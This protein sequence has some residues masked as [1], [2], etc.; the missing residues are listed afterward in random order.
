MES[1][2]IAEIIDP[3]TDK[4]VQ[5]GQTGELV[6][7]NLGRVCTPGIRFR[8]RDI[9]KSSSRQCGCGR[10]FRM[11]EG[12]V[13][14]RQDQ[15]VKIRGTNIFPSS[16]GLIVEKYV[17]PGYEYRIIAFRENDRDNIKIL[18]EKDGSEDSLKVFAHELG[19]ELK[20]DF[21]LNFKVEVLEKG[22]L[23]RFEYKAKRF[24]D[25]RKS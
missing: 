9:V 25:E 16:V 22:K 10:T 6:L 24:S 3:E 7:T 11:L 20:K 15:M 4:P 13:L 23:P 14:G 12:G 18:I 5:E 17:D 2:F 21:N 19:A 1:E 8:T